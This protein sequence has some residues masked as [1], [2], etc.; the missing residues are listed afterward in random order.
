MSNTI[1]TCQIRIQKFHLLHLCLW[2]TSKKEKQQEKV[3]CLNSLSFPQDKRLHPFT[4][5]RL[6]MSHIHRYS[7]VSLHVQKCIHNIIHMAFQLHVELICVWYLEAQIMT[8]G[9]NFSPSFQMFPF[10]VN[11]FLN[12]FWINLNIGLGESITLKSVKFALWRQ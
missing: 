7:T 5:S 1:A 11:Y 8:L 10:S 9:N 4:W 6:I 2:F 12:N 3:T